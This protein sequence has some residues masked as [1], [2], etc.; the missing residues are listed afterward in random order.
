MSKAF[1]T[2]K[3]NEDGLNQQ[4]KLIALGQLTSNIAHEIRNP[5]S[6][7]SHACQLLEE[8][9]SIQ[10]S[11]KH[12]LSIISRNVQR[13]N[14]M[15]DEI[16]NAHHHDPSKI[17]SLQLNK[18]LK[19]F[20]AY[21]C[22]MEKIPAHQFQLSVISECVHIEFNPLHLDQI[23]WNLCRNGWRYCRKSSASLEL[24]LQEN[25][26]SLLTLAVRNDGE[27]I[28]PEDQPRLFEPFYTTETKGTGLG[29]YVSRELCLRNHASL[30]FKSSETSTIFSIQL[31]RKR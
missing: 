31:K 22:E 15:I 24:S 7:I 18:F 3:A 16:L 5:L 13:I 30:D 11:S 26:K 20:H 10:N 19:D 25:P 2:L 8:D 28:A 6:A 9:A 1:D 21:F 17:V 29:L 14:Q 27:A 4:A 23:L 12:I